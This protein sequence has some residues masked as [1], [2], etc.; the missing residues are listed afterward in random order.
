MVKVKSIEFFHNGD[1]TFC[2]VEL[3]VP[4]QKIE[5]ALVGISLMKNGTFEPDFGP[6][7]KTSHQRVKFTGH[8]VKHP[9]DKY[10]VDVANKH[11]LE[12]AIRSLCKTDRDAV[13]AWFLKHPVSDTYQDL[14]FEDTL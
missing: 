9:K 12:D 8:T 14:P 5:V 1:H 7:I 2:V 13:W 4:V 3:K 10:S 6:M 11:A